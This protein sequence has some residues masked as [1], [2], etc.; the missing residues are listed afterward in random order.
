MG[1]RLKREIWLTDM[2]G[3]AQEV[4]GSVLLHGGFSFR[5]LSTDRP[6]YLIDH[7]LWI[8]VVRPGTERRFMNTCTLS[9]CDTDDSLRKVVAEMKLLPLDE[10]MMS[11]FRFGC[12][13][14]GVREFLSK[15]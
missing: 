7:Q 2:S 5:D 3:V 1:N 4:C 11:I 10:F 8:C 6:R 12:L 14:Y 15:L 13:S 9:W